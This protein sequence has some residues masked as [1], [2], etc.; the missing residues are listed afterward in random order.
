[1]KNATVV[2][3]AARTGLLSVMIVVAGC[4]KEPSSSSTTL[5]PEG[6]PVTVT[7]GS[8]TWRLGGITV[9]GTNI[10]GTN[11]TV[12]IRTREASK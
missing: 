3:N 9:N 12:G 7:D 4:S 6:K 5:P 8:N 1:M 10:S 2:K 11:V